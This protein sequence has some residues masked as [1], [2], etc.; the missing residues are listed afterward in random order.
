MRRALKVHPDL[1]RGPVTRI[2]VGIER[3]EPGILAIAY[4]LTGHLDALRVPEPVR[5]QRTD[6]L[7][8]STCF[9]AFLAPG[10]GPAYL[11]FNLSPSGRWAAYQF[12]GYRSGMAP[13]E[14][15]PPRIELES[16]AD[17]L[18]LKA[19]LDLRDLPGMTGPGAWRLGLSAVIQDTDGHIAYWA[20]AHP[21]G[22]PDFHHADGFACLVRA[23]EAS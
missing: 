21:P 13:L 18:A 4:E 22:K 15:P 12:G 10:E 1:S 5:P 8:R 9:E 19:L 23:P 2:E 20:L 16:D 6:G 17:R 7:W 11:E 3:P 14:A